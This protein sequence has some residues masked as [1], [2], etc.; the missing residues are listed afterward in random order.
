M[1]RFVFSDIK[2]LSRSYYSK[3]FVI[4]IPFVQFSIV[5]A[6]FAYFNIVVDGISVKLLWKLCFI[7]TGLIVFVD[8]I[9]ISFIIHHINCH[10]R[11]TFMELGKKCLVISIHSQTVFDKFKPK[12]YKKLYVINYKDIDNIRL[13]KGKICVK[14]KINVYYEKS[15]T[16]FYTFN[17]Y[18][19][20]FDNWWYNYNPT[21]TLDTLKLKN[22]YIQT[23]R[24]LFQARKLSV[25][26]KAIDLKHRE[27]TENML[28]LAQ[29]VRLKKKVYRSYASRHSNSPNKKRG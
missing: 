9:L 3:L 28:K 25:Y 11:F 2:K 14:G 1:N 5:M 21:K 26:E 12:Y 16:L 29:Q 15:D 22:Y 6:F 18:G 10:R 13:V 17:A 27:F 4:N 8:I 23:S 20:A 7:S 24:T 19:I